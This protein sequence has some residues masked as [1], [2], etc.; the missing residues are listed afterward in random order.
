[1][2]HNSQTGRHDLLSWSLKKS[3]S[4]YSNYVEKP[5]NIPCLQRLSWKVDLMMV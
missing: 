1:M 2:S 3:I 5:S 4:E